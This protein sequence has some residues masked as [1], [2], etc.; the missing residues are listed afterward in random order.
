V[1][2]LDDGGG[3][4]MLGSRMPAGPG[5]Q[6]H[7]KRAQALAAGVNNVSGDLVDQCNGA[8]Q[9]LFDDPVNGVKIGTDQ[10]ANSF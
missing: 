8:V 3:V 1:D 9:T 2:E 6:K 10:V 7:Q 4:Y 5:R